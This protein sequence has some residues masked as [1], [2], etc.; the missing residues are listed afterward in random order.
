MPCNINL[1]VDLPCSNRFMHFNTFSCMHMTLNVLHISRASCALFHSQ[2][3]LLYNI[4]LLI[5]VSVMCNKHLLKTVSAYTMWQQLPAMC[6]YHSV[7]VYLSQVWLY[8]NQCCLYEMQRKHDLTYFCFYTNINC[9]VILK[10][11]DE[12]CGYPGWLTVRR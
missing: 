9:H 11:H 7:A 2:H 10:L 5:F 8:W 3:Y 6:T 12:V 1:G 4:D